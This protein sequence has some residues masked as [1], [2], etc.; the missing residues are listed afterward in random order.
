LD[1]HFRLVEVET[2]CCSS[3]PFF[4]PARYLPSGADLL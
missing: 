2:F 4:D 3:A 1:A